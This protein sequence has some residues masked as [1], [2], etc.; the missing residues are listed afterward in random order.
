MKVQ[1][2]MVVEI[3]A[4]KNAVKATNGWQWISPLGAEK[5]LILRIQKNADWFQR[6]G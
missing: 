5:F 2:F 6:I 3:H 1:W 4:N